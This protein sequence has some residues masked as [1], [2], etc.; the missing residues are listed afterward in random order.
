MLELP[1]AQYFL[2]YTIINVSSIMTL[3]IIVS[4]LYWGATFLQI[5]CQAK[6]FA[7]YEYAGGPTSVL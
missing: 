6:S 2:H 1:P 5:A 7:L 3:T 4:N